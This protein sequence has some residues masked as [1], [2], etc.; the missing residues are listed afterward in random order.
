MTNSLIGTEPQPTLQQC[1][2]TRFH[3]FPV[4]PHPLGGK[5]TLKIKRCFCKTKCL[6]VEENKW[7]VWFT[8]IHPQTWPDS[9]LLRSNLRARVQS[10]SPQSW[11]PKGNLHRSENARSG[12]EL[13]EAHQGRWPGGSGGTPPGPSPA[14][15]PSFVSSFQLSFWVEGE[16]CQ[17]SSLQ[18]AARK[19]KHINHRPSSSVWM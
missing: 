19:H 5:S 4:H 3:F 7:P 13:W 6:V 1:I 2:E 16:F 14:S 12:P 8:Q 15:L 18:Q 17:F 10:V 11:E 9:G